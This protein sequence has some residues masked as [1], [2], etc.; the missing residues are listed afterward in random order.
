MDRNSIFRRVHPSRDWRRI[1]RRLCQAGVEHRHAAAACEDRDELTVLGSSRA[2][3]PA[4]E[5][6]RAQTGSCLMHH[7]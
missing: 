2:A 5:N 7:W 3:S 1:R 6:W 4:S